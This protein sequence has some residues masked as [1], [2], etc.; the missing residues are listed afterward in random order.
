MKIK[1]NKGITLVTLVITVII[2]VILAGTGVSIGLNL[3]ATAKYT[4]VQTYMLLIQQK[5]EYVENEVVIGE[6]EE[7][8]RYGELQEDGDLPGWYKLSQGDLNEMGVK[9]QKQKTGYYVNYNT[10]KG[11]DVIYKP[12]VV[13]DG[14]TYYKL[15]EMLEA[16]K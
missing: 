4:N 11:V 15:T 7:D 3:T 1:E 6:M 9:V 5:C 12:G 8:D 16:G 13:N 10:E 2:L 14:E